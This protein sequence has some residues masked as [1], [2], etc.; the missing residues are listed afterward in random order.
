MKK[1][2]WVRAL[3]CALLAALIM[4]SSMPLALAAPVADVAAKKLVKATVVKLSK[5]KAT[6]Y[7]G[8]DGAKSQL[9]LSYTIKPASASA[10]D[11]ALGLVRWSSSKNKVATVDA[12]GVVTP[13]APGACK[14]TV[15]L[16]D[17]SKKKASCT[18]TVKPVLPKS[19]SMQPLTVAVG[20]SNYLS[21]AIQPGDAY[22]QKLSF[23]SSNK[24]VATVSASGEVRAIKKG[25]A[26]ITAT[27]KAG[28]KKASCTVTVTDPPPVEPGNS[29]AAKYFFYGIG[30]SAY[31]GDHALTSCVLDLNAMDAVYAAA[32]FSGAKVQRVMRRNL[33]AQGIVSLLSEMANN[34][35]ITKDDVTFFYYSGHGM[36][37]DMASAR[38]AL[39]GVDMNGVTVNRVQSYLDRVPG[40]VIVFLDSCL[41]GQFIQSKGVSGKTPAQAFNQD[42]INC[43]AGSTA[44]N[45]SAKAL[46]GSPYSAKYK[47]L[48]A[49]MP[50]QSSY[51]LITTNP[52][53]DFGVFTRA[54]TNGLGK[55]KPPADA[56]GDR[57]VSLDELYRYVYPSVNNALLGC[58][59]DGQPIEQTVM[60]WPANDSTCVYARD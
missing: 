28:G 43:F 29:A 59:V 7:V 2:Q 20:E 9:A 12:S 4:V 42:V 57:R 21:Y 40:R 24:K 34:A 41:S 1:K 3:L 22:N 52:D 58:T 32:S 15:S 38:G 49:C 17:G 46:T 30:N 14:I 48:T 18:V 35:S 31:P 44:K 19:L 51:S 26:K 11:D 10:R 54:I 39:V 55:S 27:T 45:F 60:V 16:L 8:S 37:S 50:M 6:L 53:D 13:V 33:T 5:T 56:N 47:I 25:T 23:S 36:S